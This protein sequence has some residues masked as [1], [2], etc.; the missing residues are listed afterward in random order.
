MAFDLASV[1]SQ[2]TGGQSSPNVH[3]DFD[4]V[5][6]NAPPGMLQSGLA[7]MFN[8]PQTPAFGQMAGQLFGNA[9][10]HQQA[11]MLSQLLNGMGPSVLASLASGVGGGALGGLLSRFT[12]GGAAPQ[13]TPDQASQLSPADVETVANHAE[14]HAPGIV[15]RMSEFYAQH[16]DLVKT[17][18]GAALTVALA[19][20]AGPQR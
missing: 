4:R 2:F 18:G 16:P 15:D 17:L 12:G 14:Q 8:S 11:G 13:V 3:D 20:M 10:P 9:A 6:Q 19:K 7:G 5:A 1:L